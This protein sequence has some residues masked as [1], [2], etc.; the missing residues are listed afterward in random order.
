MK[1]G[2]GTKFTVGLCVDWPDG[3]TPDTYTP[4]LKVTEVDRE[5]KKVR[6]ELDDTPPPVVYQ[7]PHRFKEWRYT[8]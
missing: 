6:F 2:E 8:K 7:S 3:W 4:L 1:R 5:N